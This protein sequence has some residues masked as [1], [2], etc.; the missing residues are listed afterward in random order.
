MK[1]K[2]LK[3]SMVAVVALSGVLL[4][5]G[6]NA[7]E[8]RSTQ[9]GP[10]AEKPNIIFML[11]DDQRYDALGVMGNPIINTPHLDRLASLD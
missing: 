1:N 4:L 11:T 5:Q 6:S 7:V 8:N 10:K 3:I 9:A 2:G